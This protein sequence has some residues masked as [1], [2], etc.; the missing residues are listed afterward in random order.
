MTNVCDD[1]NEN[2]KNFIFI[3]LEKREN[4]VDIIDLT[5]IVIHDIFDDVIDENV[6]IKIMKNINE[7]DVS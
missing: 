3:D 1:V 4:F 2:I 5:T 6:K 7:I